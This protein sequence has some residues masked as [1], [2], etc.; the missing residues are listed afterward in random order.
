M[1]NQA[2]KGD[3]YATRTYLDCRQRAFE[4]AALRESSQSSNSEKDNDVKTLTGEELMRIAAGGLKD[5]E[6][7]KKG[8]ISNTD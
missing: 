8:H 7:E 3:R 6:Q 4:R 2:M 1:I 5:T